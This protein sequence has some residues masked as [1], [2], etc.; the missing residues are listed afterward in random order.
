LQSHAA[1]TARDLL[2]IAEIILRARGH[3]G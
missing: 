1:A 3:V 2:R